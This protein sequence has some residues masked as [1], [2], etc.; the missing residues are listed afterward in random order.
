[1]SISIKE[2]N[3]QDGSKK[4]RL[5][6]PYHPD[7]PK[8]AKAM[9]GKFNGDAKAWYFDLRTLGAVR[10]MSLEVY[11]IDPLAEPEE[12]VNVRIFNDI[13]NLPGEQTVWAMGREIVSRPSRDA[14][15][16]VGQGVAVVAGGFKSS[17]GSRNNPSIGSC[18]PGTVIEVYDVPR[19]VAQTWIDSGWQNDAEIFV[20]A[21]AEETSVA[22]ENAKVLA[23]QL[24]KIMPALTE[25]QMSEIMHIVTATK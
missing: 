1:M 3:M 21:P 12:M 23:E 7:L 24:S 8:R 25:A 16:R 6:S 5:D 15:V 4:I 10:Q 2:V 19:S 9:G 20:V 13:D 14:S 18:L 11:G 22:F 17:G